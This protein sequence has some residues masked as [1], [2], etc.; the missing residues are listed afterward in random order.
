MFN[1]LRILTNKRAVKLID[2]VRS[3]MEN[4]GRNVRRCLV[5]VAAILYITCMYESVQSEI[6]EKMLR[7]VLKLW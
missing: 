4:I 2:T 6:L 5:L 1:K 7:K 3:G